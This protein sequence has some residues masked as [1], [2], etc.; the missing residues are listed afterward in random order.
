MIRPGDEVLVVATVIS[1]LDV[2]QTIDLIV[3]I[4]DID[5]EPVQLSIT[6][7]SIA[8]RDGEPLTREPIEKL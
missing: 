7:A 3:E 2:S 5:G 8:H 4:V 6:D 1:A